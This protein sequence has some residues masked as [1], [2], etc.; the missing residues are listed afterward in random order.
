M[1]VLSQYRKWGQSENRTFNL[2]GQYEL[3]GRKRRVSNRN[4]CSQGAAHYHHLSIKLVCE[5]F[6]HAGTKPG[7]RLSEHTI[8]LTGAIVGDRELPICS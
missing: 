3:R 6:N 4:F 8:R 7:F 2:V 1:S 5:R